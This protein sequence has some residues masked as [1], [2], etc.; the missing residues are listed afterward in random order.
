MRK[1]LK[2]AGANDVTRVTAPTQFDLG[3]GLMLRSVQ[4]QDDADRYAAFNAEFVSDIQGLTC[5][6]LL[7][8]HPMMRWDDFFFVE[9]SSTKKMVSCTCLIPW[10]CRLGSGEAQVELQ[11]AMLEM[12]VTHPEYR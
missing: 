6:K 10:V 8:Y 2:D 9:E 5:A 1:I 12:V 3:N 7:A 4:S 11:V